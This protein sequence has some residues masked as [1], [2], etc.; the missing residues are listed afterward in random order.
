MLR[1]R[2]SL[3]LGGA[4]LLLL[5]LLAMSAAVESRAGAAD[6]NP[7]VLENQQP[8]TTAWKLGQNGKQISNDA[9]GQIKG[10]ASATSV[11][12]GGSI[13]FNVS[14]SPAQSYTIDVYR[15]GCY[16]DAAGNCLGGRLMQSLGQ[17]DGIQQPPCSVEQTRA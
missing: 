17:F 16:P 2:R 11:N 7:I 6:S 3:V 9:T 8:G 15:L 13:S 12:L 14:V 4:F 10:Y 5:A 1:R